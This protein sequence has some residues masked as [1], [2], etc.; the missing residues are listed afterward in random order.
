MLSG[1]LSGLWVTGS[2]DLNED[3]CIW[4][5]M[6]KFGRPV[7]IQLKSL[8]VLERLLSP[9]RLELTEECG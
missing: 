5:E 2:Q 4:G 8:S 9:I 6:L 3:D 7:I 1:T